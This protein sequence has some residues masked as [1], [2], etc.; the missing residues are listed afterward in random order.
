MTDKIIFKSTS[1]PLKA[2]NATDLEVGELILNL[3]DGKLYFK[4][5]DGT[6]VVIGSN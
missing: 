1:V 4:K 6:I 5:D 3:A 2:P